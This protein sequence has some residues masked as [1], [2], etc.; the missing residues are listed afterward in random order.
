MTRKKS[1]FL[2]VKCIVSSKPI[3]N[4]QKKS[5]RDAAA[6]LGVPQ[7]TNK[8]ETLMAASDGDS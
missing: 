2:S 6:K 8:R 7:A 1:N 5:Q 3:T 4:C